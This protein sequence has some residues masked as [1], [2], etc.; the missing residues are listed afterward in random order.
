MDKENK[1][2]NKLNK[3]SSELF[4]LFLT[5]FN[6]NV[7]DAELFYKFL[8]NDIISQKKINTEKNK[9]EKSNIDLEYI[10][11]NPREI[12]EEYIEELLENNENK[13]NLYN[14]IK[15]RLNKK[16]IEIKKKIEECNK[17]IDIIKKIYV[18]ILFEKILPQNISNQ[19][20]FKNKSVLTY[21]LSKNSSL[22]LGEIFSRYILTSIN[23]NNESS[24]E[25]FYDS[26][27]IHSFYDKSININLNN[28]EENNSNNEKNN[29]N[30]EE[31][32]GNN[33]KNNN[34]E[35]NITNNKENNTNNKENNGNNLIK[36]G[37]NKKKNATF[38]TVDKLN[39]SVKIE[40][41]NFKDM[42]NNFRYWIFHI[43]I[44][45]NLFS[46]NSDYKIIYN[47]KQ[48]LE[49]VNKLI[50]KDDEQQY[51]KRDD[52]Q[53]GKKDEQHRKKEQYKMQKYKTQRGGDNNEDFKIKLGAEIIKNLHKKSIDE[54]TKNKQKN[55]ET[56]ARKPYF[57]VFNNCYV[58]PENNKSL[59]KIYIDIFNSTLKD[60]IKQTI[61]NKVTQNYEIY[62]PFYPFAEKFKRPLKY[63]LKNEIKNRNITQSNIQ[64]NLNFDIF[65]S[66]V[67]FEDDNNKEFIDKFTK[68]L[69]MKLILT[70]F[71]LYKIKKN[72]YEKY[73]EILN[74]KI[75]LNK[76]NTEITI[77]NAKKE[78]ERS[79][80]IN[81]QMGIPTISKKNSSISERIKEINKML[82]FYKKEIKSLD[83]KKGIKNYDKMILNIE[84][85]IKKLVIE[86]YELV[87]KL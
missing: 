3:D 15:E 30:N 10:F 55:K 5:Y 14:L 21:S 41:N 80:K 64:N 40:I 20:L 34:N 78:L 57:E 81:S 23:K 9:S 52:K 27:N 75:G 28:N 2:L 70:I 54:K 18:D 82:D 50:K 63:Y 19:L 37:N 58:N 85:L 36:K 39:E 71:Y 84:N 1:I 25:M 72:I 49:E 35:E 77:E 22:K 53:H 66:L 69:K 47:E 87:S 62:N 46:N 79:N 42:N 33:E 43:K 38:G 31:N 76:N 16:K 24:V 8:F 68:E 67:F 74:D 13:N 59:K 73:I 83:D 56:S 61:P 7:H 29:N 26:S 6:E 11:E 44:I 48:F 45:E 32:N 51:K 60:W 4:E 65:Q 17:D 12:I 86:K